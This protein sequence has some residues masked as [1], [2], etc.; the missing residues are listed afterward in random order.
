MLKFKTLWSHNLIRF[1]IVYNS[2]QI[3][4]V[5]LK[6]IEKSFIGMKQKSGLKKS[7]DSV[8]SY[9]ANRRF[10]RY[11]SSPIVVWQPLYFVIRNLGVFQGL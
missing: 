4:F 1:T 7:Q 3:L 10:A 5:M 2:F 8:G 6:S 9:S 11:H